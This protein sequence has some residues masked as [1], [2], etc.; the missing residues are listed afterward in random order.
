MTDDYVF[1]AGFQQHGGRAFTGVCTLGF[2][3]YVLRTDLYIGT[4]GS[5]CS[6]GDVHKGNAQYYVT[7]GLAF[8]QSSGFLYG[9]HSFGGG[10]VHLPVACDNNLAYFFFHVGI[11]S[12]L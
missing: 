6:Y 4:P 5:F 12:F 7:A 8:Y 9:G 10:H 11:P 3:M 2:K 1:R